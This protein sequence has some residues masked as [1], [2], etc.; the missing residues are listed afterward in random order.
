M[1]YR[2]SRLFYPVKDKPL[3]LRVYSGLRRQAFTAR[4]GLRQSSGRVLGSE[5]STFR[6]VFEYSARNT[7][8]FGRPSNTRLGILDFSAD[9]RILGSEYSTFR[10]NFR[11]QSL[12]NRLSKSLE[13]SCASC[14]DYGPLR[15]KISS[16]SDQRFPSDCSR[17]LGRKNL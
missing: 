4:L 16:N 14:P 10:P 8:L 17:K 9:L 12:G 6:P 2:R 3:E 11:V 1:H 5:Y 15:I 13:N 7:R